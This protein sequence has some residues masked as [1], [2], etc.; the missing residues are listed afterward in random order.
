MA[1]YLTSDHHFWHANVIRYCSRPY[2]SV[3]E[4]NEMLVK[5]WNDV[6]GPD[7]TVYHLGDFSMAFR[8]V[9]LYTKRL[10]GKKI[11]ICGNHDF[12]HPV[13]RKS[14]HPEN[15]AKWIQKYLENGWDEVHEHMTLDI[16]G[17]AVVNLSHMPYA[18][19]DPSQ[20]QRYLKWRLKDD[21]RWLLCGHVHEKWKQRGKMINVG[22][23]VWDYKPVHVDEISKLIL[24][25]QS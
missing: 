6:V 23:D 4:M 2:A 21:G 1:I 16:P 11:L 15:R 7:D 8:S 24:S 14:R 22:V 12:C 10:M 3:E 9:E 18:D 17:V 13:N 25:P 19:P 5:N 20:D